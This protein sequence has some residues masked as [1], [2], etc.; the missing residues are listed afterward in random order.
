MYKCQSK[1]KYSVLYPSYQ[2]PLLGDS[3]KSFT[4]K[5]TKY[6]VCLKNGINAYAFSSLQNTFH[7]IESLVSAFVLNWYFLLCMLMFL[8]S[9]LLFSIMLLWYWCPSYGFLVFILFSS[10]LHLTS[11]VVFLGLN[12]INELI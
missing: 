8:A 3:N 5:R 4:V 7:Q 6:D 12:M 9:Y 1:L 11:N 2:V 10:G